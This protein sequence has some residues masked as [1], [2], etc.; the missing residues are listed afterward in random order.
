MKF[1]HNIQQ[2]FLICPFSIL[3]HLTLS[4]PMVYPPLSE[5]YSQFL[6]TT[7]F[8]TGYSW[9]LFPFSPFPLASYVCFRSFPQRS[10][11]STV[12]RS[13]V[14]LYLFPL[15]YIAKAK[16]WL[17]KTE[18]SLEGRRKGEV[19]EAKA[20]FSLEGGKEEDY[21][22]LYI[23]DLVITDHHHLRISVPWMPKS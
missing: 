7:S 22:H 16:N 3:L 17:A 10:L 4:H 23:S 12:A 15:F 14:S 8:K 20:E 9:L 11:H 13:F 18:V 1:N 21:K 19:E 6:S 5:S 2:Y